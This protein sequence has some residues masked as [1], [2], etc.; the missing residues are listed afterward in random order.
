MRAGSGRNIA[1][2]ANAICMERD[3]LRDALAKLTESYDEKTRQDIAL[4]KRIGTYQLKQQIGLGNFGKVK[5][6]IHLLTN[7]L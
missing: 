1:D 6:G 7:G 2:S 4:G 5:L 3:C